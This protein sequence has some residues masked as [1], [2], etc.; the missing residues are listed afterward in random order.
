[1]AAETV[2]GVRDVQSVKP[3]IEEDVYK[4]K[5]SALRDYLLRGVGRWRRPHFVGILG[6]RVGIL[7]R[8]RGE[9]DGT[10]S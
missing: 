8:V 4:M 1:M 2:L 5:A 7:W 3:L 6:G 10:A 9:Q